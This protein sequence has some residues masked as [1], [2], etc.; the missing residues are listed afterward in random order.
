METNVVFVPIISRPMA[1]PPVWLTTPEA[2]DAFTDEE[3][4]AGDSGIVL[5]VQRAFA[6]ADVRDVQIPQHPKLAVVLHGEGADAT[7]V[8]DGQPGI[9]RHGGRIR[10]GHDAGGVIVPAKVRAPALNRIRVAIQEHGRSGTT[11]FPNVQSPLLVKVELPF[12]VNT[13][14]ARLPEIVVIAH[15]EVPRPELGV[16]QRQAWKGYPSDP[17][18]RPTASQLS[19]FRV[20]LLST[21][22][23]PRRECCR[24]RIRSGND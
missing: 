24:Q 15:G 13:C 17:L 11:A 7:F 4:I 19:I 3:V 1:E 20:V 9:D 8:A 12:R 16:I 14:W 2:A 10:N 23:A 5:D 21:S 6:Q 18:P 22:E